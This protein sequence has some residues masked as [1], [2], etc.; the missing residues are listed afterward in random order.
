MSKNVSRRS[1]T[2]V[3]GIAR[4][5]YDVRSDADVT[6]TARNAAWYV[7]ANDV[8]RN[9]TADDVARNATANDVAWNG[10][11]T[12]ANGNVSYATTSATTRNH[13]ER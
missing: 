1:I 2:N 12:I 9:A 6:W 8:A 4:L 5:T 13:G 10:I 11:P 7:I 3:A